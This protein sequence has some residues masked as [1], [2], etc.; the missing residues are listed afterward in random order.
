M[1]GFRGTVNRVEFIGRL[2]ADPEARQV[3]TGQV[4]RLRLATY[5]PQRANEEDQGAYGTDWWTVG[6]PR[7]A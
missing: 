6:A 7:S 3:G 4:V 1:D 5:Y 2:G